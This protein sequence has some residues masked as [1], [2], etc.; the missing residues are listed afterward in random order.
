[1][2]LQ[3]TPQ[4]YFEMVNG[5]LT[6]ISA[7]TLNDVGVRGLFELDANGDIVPMN[8]GYPDGYLDLEQDG[9]GIK[10]KA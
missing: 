1:M 4:T 2:R 7:I 9:T 10:P 5:D 8:A 3:G 6:P